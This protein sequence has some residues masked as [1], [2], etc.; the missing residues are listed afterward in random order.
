MATATLPLV[1]VEE[2]LHTVYEPD[3]DYVDGQIEERSMGEWDHGD[4]QGQIY[5]IFKRNGTE[6]GIRTAP[7][8][9]V[10][11]SPTR[12]RVPDVCVVSAAEPKQQVVKTPPLLCIEVLSPEDRYSQS[13]R[14][15]DDYIQMG[16]REVWIFDPGTRT[17]YVLRQDRVTSTYR[18][19]T[20]RLDGTPIELSL[21]EVFGVLDIS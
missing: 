3:A 1:T 19:G 11:T 10:Q 13:A 14:K 7:E 9:R 17:A 5:L 2:Y 12:Y 15:Y 16:V 8:I 6:W 21:A 18:E 20:L 4:V